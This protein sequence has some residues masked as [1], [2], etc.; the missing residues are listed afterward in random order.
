M[1]EAYQNKIQSMKEI[2][3]FFEQTYETEN[4][5]KHNSLCNVF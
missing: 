1:R 4:K 5:L 3:N 2:N